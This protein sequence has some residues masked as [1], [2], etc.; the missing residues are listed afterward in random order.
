M[1]CFSSEIFKF[2]YNLKQLLQKRSHCTF[3]YLRV[4]ESIKPVMD[5][6]TLR[7]IFHNAKYTEEQI[8][9]M[10]HQLNQLKNDR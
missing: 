7:E 4:C 9:Q 1:G 3:G 5:T 8:E 6:R 2:I 10:N